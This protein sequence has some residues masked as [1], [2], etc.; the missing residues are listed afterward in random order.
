MLTGS[1]RVAGAGCCRLM[2]CLLAQA[3]FLAN[4]RAQPR[5]FPEEASSAPAAAAASA[6]V[7]RSGSEGGLMPAKPFPWQPGAY[8]GLDRLWAAGAF[9]GEFRAD[10]AYH[11]SLA[12]PADNTITGSSEVFRHGEV[13]ATQLGLGG[14]FFYQGAHGRVMTQFGMYSQTTP[15]ND[16][17]SARG[18]WSLADAYRAISEGYGGYRWEVLGGLNLQAGIFTSYVGLWSYYNF[19]NWTYQPSYISSN[20]P[21]F[22]EGVRAQLFVSERLKIEPWL[23]NGWQAYGG[24]NRWPGFGGQVVWRPTEALSFTFNQYV[25]VD[26]LGNPGRKRMHTDDSAMW[27][28]Y[29]SS[30]GLVRRMA[31]SLTVDAG[32]ESGGGVTCGSQNMVGVMAYHRI[33]FARDQGA[34]TVGGGAVRNPGRYLALIPPINGA[35]ALSGTPYFSTNPGDPFVAWDTQMT[36]D[37]LPT[38]YVIVRAEYTHRAASQP[39]F[40]GSGG[41]TPPGGNQGPKGSLLPNW[42]PDLRK[43]EDRFTLAL[44]VKI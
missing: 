38:P 39:Y 13:Q 25:G 9:T 10:I 28:Y 23:V 18:Q 14:D 2:L 7:D 29:D 35:D 24:L 21:W 4:A 33:W 40:S 44:L 5:N 22:F 11:H 6:A 27:K 37:F 15:R 12:R 42:T 20:T 41:V 30:S 31:A 16:P 19:E 43:T 32:C 8:A 26:T 34:I 3:G 36:L 1:K 17:S